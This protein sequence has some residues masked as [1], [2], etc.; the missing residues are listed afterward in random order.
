VPVFLIDN[1]EL[2]KFQF[3]EFEQQLINDFPD[4]KRSALILSL[5]S[6]SKKMVEVK[7]NELRR[8]IW[9]VA[10]LA[11]LV[12]TAPI[13]GL[14]ITVN[15]LIIAEEARFFMTQLGL[16]EKSLN[17]IAKS[18]LVDYSAVK[19]IVNDVLKI[20]VV[21]VDMISKFLLSYLSSVSKSAAEEMADSFG[22][23]IAVPAAFGSV[24]LA[25]TKILDKFEM[26]AIEVITFVAESACKTV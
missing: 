19:C 17:R 7:V 14:S 2:Q 25:M 12:A 22:N 15:S 4:L 13:P 24:Y 23:I 6:T 26:A 11:A 5:R 20:D 1:Y 8:R 18:H 3:E 16:N 21:V 10:I 9:K